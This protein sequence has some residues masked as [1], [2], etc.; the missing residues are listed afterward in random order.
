[1]RPSLA[2]S[3]LAGL[4]VGVWGLGVEGTASIG[5]LT[6]MGIEPVLADDNPPA[7]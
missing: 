2:W 7:G 6:S 5:R 3:D 4:R 1:M